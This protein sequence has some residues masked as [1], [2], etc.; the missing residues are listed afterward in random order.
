MRYLILALAILL[1]SACATTGTAFVRECPT[2]IVDNQ[3]YY[4]VT[5]YNN[6]GVRLERVEGFTRRGFRDC[7][8][9]HRPAV[10]RVVGQAGAFAL[11]LRGNSSYL[12]PDNLLEIRIG[13]SP[14]LSQ[15]IYE[16]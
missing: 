5:L 16:R 13:V 6:V 11:T 8:L 12:L 2:V 4:G 10:I 15:V 14:N 3:N 1:S 7:A 9:L